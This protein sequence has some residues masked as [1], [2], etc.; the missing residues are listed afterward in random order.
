MVQKF[1][2]SRASQAVLCSFL[3]SH[4]HMHLE[5]QVILS[6]IV[7]NFTE[8]TQEGVFVY[9]EFSALLELVDLTEGYYPWTVHLGPLHNACLQELLVGGPCLPLSA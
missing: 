5:V 2:F 7:G 3:Q 1:V 8:E 9:E 4:D 6:Y